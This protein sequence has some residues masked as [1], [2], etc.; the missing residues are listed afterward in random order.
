V[1][2]LYAALFVL[3]GAIP[4]NAQTRLAVIV[5]TFPDV[6]LPPYDVVSATQAE[7]TH[8]ETYYAE[9]SYDRFT[10]DGDVFGL[11]TV[12]RPVNPVSAVDAR[13]QITTAAKLAASAAGVDLSPYPANRF[14]Y[15]LP[16]TTFIAAGYGDNS[17]VWIALHPGFTAAPQF[18]ILAHE[19]GHH[20]WGLAHAR[21][22]AYS[23]GTPLG[24]NGGTCLGNFNQGDSLDVMGH[25][26]LSFGPIVKRTLGWLDASQV[27]AAA[28]DGDYTITPY[29]T[30]G[31]VKALT[32]QGGTNK[33]PVTYWVHYR[34]PV[35]ADAGLNPWTDPANLF[36]GAVLHLPGFG[37]LGAQLLKMTPSA[38]SDIDTPA[39]LVGQT[40]CE[41]MGER[42]SIAPLSATS[43][44][45][46]LRVTIGKCK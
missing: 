3:C 37:T 28:K 31:G 25:G 5:V 6:S 2:L 34:Q 46:V 9:Q 4:A 30:P 27:V 41:P 7:L 18:Q 42:A 24:T 40:W 36:N 33:N 8:V 45:L 13:Q 23:D 16:Q 12:D 17:G 43:A 29:G 32:F 39:L 10:L 15:I 19:L 21:G 44:G 22:C 35:G 1:K 14:V 20:F 11:Y 38:D 26:Y